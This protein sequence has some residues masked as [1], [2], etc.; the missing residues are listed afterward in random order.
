MSN[1]FENL[2]STMSNE[3]NTKLNEMQKT[4]SETLTEKIKLEQ[5]DETIKK[6]NNNFENI[7][8]VAISSNS[9][10]NNSQIQQLEKRISEL[11]TQ[12]Q[13]EQD[14][15]TSIKN[16]FI[17][18]KNKV[19]Y[20]NKHEKVS[21]EELQSIKQRQEAMAKKLEENKRIIDQNGS[22]A[23]SQRDMIQQLTK[24]NQELK[25]KIEDGNSDQHRLRSD[26]TKIEE[27]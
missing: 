13:R 9:E 26:L 14:E 21:K 20:D 27:N 15:K 2:K 1:N 7:S 18:L 10:K 22:E 11:T 12:I 17:M 16:E 23:S 8:K 4:I 25:L 3:Y 5:F 6:L 24:E 19:E